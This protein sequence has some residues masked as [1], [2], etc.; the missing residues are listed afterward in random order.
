MPVSPHPNCHEPLPDTVIRRFT[1]FRKFYDLLATEELYFRQTD[2]FK[3]TDPQEALASDQY[4][5]ATFGLHRYDINDE[6]R[7]I[8][9]QGFDRQNSEAHYI[10]C[11]QIFEGETLEMWGRYDTGVVRYGEKDMRG[12]NLINFLFTKRQC[13]EKER[14]LRV[15]WQSYNPVGE[16]N[17]HISP[18]GV[19]N[20][21]PLSELDPLPDWV[22]EC[23]RRRIDR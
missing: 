13:F 21:E 17:R 10:N 16:A 1:D 3:E 15:V 11:W 23:K 19:F 18:E 7:L 5:R 12:V 14:E 6:I 4:L 2:L 22:H 8:D 20:R 9:T